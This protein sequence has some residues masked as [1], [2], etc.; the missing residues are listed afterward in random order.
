MKIFTRVLFFLSYLLLL[1]TCDKFDIQVNEAIAITDYDPVHETKKKN[2]LHLLDTVAHSDQLLIG[3]NIGHADGSLTYEFYSDL[4][5]QPSVLALDLGYN[6]LI[7]D[8]Q[9]L[10]ETIIQHSDKG[11]LVTISTH[12]PNPFNQKNVHNKAA[13]DLNELLNTETAAHQNFQQLLLNI[14]NFFQL[15][16]NQEVIVL[17]RPF[18][19]MNGGW[20][21]WGNDKNWASKEAF[22]AMWKYTHDYLQNQRQ[23]DNL[24][25]VYAPN[26]QEKRT[27]KSVLHYYP[28]EDYVDIVALDYYA[29]DLTQI[30]TNNSLSDLQ[31][32]GKPIG[33]AEIGNKTLRNGQFDNLTYLGLNEWVGVSYFVAWHSYPNNKIAIRDCQNAAELMNHRWIIDLSEL[34]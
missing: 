30:D 28:G 23:L 8:N 29:D 16:K 25:W 27:Q 31:K 7:V 3:Q 11:G 22:V 13:F 14:G 20:F 18:H 21:W 6:E 15:L 2:I 24:L 9:Q 26:F 12:M 10:I 1:T 17:F 19:E 33:I 4:P 5:Q 32:L 34:E